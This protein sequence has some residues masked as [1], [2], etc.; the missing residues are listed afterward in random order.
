MLVFVTSVC[1]GCSYADTFEE[2]EKV[3]SVFQQASAIEGPITDEQLS[4]VPVHKSGSRKRKPLHDQE[5]SSNS[6]DDIR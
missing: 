1:R 4:E 5:N 2:A 3:C 6:D